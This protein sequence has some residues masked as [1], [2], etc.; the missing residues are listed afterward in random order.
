MK[1]FI[2]QSSNATTRN[3]FVTK[4]VHK[5]GADEIFGKSKS[6]TYYISGTKQLAKGAEIA[7]DYLFPRFKVQTYEFVSPKDGVVMNLKWLHRA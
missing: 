3:T 2:V 7:E 4:L 1:K 5:D 6:E